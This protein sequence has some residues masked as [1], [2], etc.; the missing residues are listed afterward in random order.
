MLLLRHDGPRAPGPDPSEDMTKAIGAS[1]PA[2]K[3]FAAR[4]RPTPRRFP[5]TE[6]SKAKR[7]T[8]NA[9]RLAS[10]AHIVFKKSIKA[11]LS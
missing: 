10:R 3:D 1:G 5:T 11:R 4:V 9:F 2:E 7:I 6:K 8:P